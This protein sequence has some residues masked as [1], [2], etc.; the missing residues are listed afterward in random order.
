MGYKRKALKEHASQ[1]L[2][3]R[4]RDL[5]SK[6]KLIKG[7]FGRRERLISRKR[8]RMPLAFGFWGYKESKEK[9][10]EFLFWPMPN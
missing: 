6:Q 9:C 8:E 1:K 5:I 4:E 3:L 2:R 7:L 10:S